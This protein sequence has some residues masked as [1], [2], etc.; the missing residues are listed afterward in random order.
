LENIM[1][2][3][4]RRVVL[5]LLAV[6][7]AI[8][9]IVIGSGSAG[10]TGHQTWPHPDCEDHVYGN[11]YCSPATTV[12]HPPSTVKCPPRSTTTTTT[13]PEV[14]VP[15]TTA[16]TPTTTPTTTTTTEVLEFPP[17]D[18][19]YHPAPPAPTPTPAP[20]APV[21]PVKKISFTG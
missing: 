15:P 18:Y 17:P 11:E 13:V 5:S 8:I 2:N 6:T 9:A 4:R 1:S 14:T 10:A 16:V 12:P 19:A 7:L 21:Q 3:N 20:P